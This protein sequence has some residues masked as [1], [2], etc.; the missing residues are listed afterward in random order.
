[1]PNSSRRCTTGLITAALAPSEITTENT[2]VTEGS[3][4][5]VVNLCWFSQRRRLARRSVQGRRPAARLSR[6]HRELS[7]MVDP[8][9]P[10]EIPPHVADRGRLIDNDFHRPV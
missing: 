5:S 1:I 9:Q 6:H 10:N 4:L 3:V 8:V 2:E 7:A